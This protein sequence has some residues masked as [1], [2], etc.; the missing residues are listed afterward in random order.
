MSDESGCR[1]GDLLPRQMDHMTDELK[2]ALAKDV[3]AHDGGTVFD[4]LGSQALDVIGN[5]LDVDVFESLA[6]A[7]SVVGELREFADAKKHPPNETATVT[8][9]AHDFTTTLHP[10]LAYQIAGIQVLSLRFN[11]DL[12]AEIKTV[13]LDI[14]ERRLIAVGASEGRVRAQLKYHSV[15]L[16]KKLES[17]AVQLIGRYA[18]PAPGFKVVGA[19]D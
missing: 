12:V 10:V 9:G 11:L 2:D 4:F 16:H 6:R 15:P 19:A 13:K 17:Q 5:A 3:G 8:L 18:L 1:L 7:W 14:R